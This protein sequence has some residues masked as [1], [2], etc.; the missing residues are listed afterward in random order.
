TAF[1]FY[2]LYYTLCKNK[3]APRTQYLRGFQSVSQQDYIVFAIFSL[4]GL[5]SVF[6]EMLTALIYRQPCL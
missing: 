2:T 1:A 4:G 3:K 6:F 5:F